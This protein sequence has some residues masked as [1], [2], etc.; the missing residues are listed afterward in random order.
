M[1]YHI[2]GGMEKMKIESKDEGIIF[3]YFFQAFE[4]TI[5]LLTVIRIKK[6]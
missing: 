6:E 3:H 2:N 4:N 5:K 1:T